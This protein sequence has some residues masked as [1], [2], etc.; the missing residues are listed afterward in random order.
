[1]TEMNIRNFC[2]ISHVDHGKST[3]AD[4]FLELTKTISYEKMKPQYLDSMS[5]ERERGITIKLQPVTM[6]YNLNLKPYVLNLIDTPGHVDFS[7]EVSRSL[8]AVEGAILLVDAGQGIQAQTL[9]NFYLARK[10]G[11][12]VI[13][14]V[15]KIDLKDIDLNSVRKELAD[16]TGLRAEEI[17]CISAKNGV[18]IEGVLRAV[19]EKIPVP[20]RN[21]KLPFRALIFDS[22]FDEFKGVVAYVRVV[23]GQIKTGDKIEFLGSEIESQVLEVGVF[24]PELKKK[25]TLSSGEIG[26]IITGLKNIEK[27]RV[28]DTI[29]AFKSETDRESGA[30][31][32]RALPGYQEPQSMV[33]AGIYPKQGA[34]QERLR[35]ALMKLKLNDASLVFEPERSLALGFGFRAGFLGLLHLDIIQERLKREYDLDLVITSPSVAYRLFKKSPLNSVISAAVRPADKKE[36]FEIIHSPSDFPDPSQI[37]EVQEPW[38]EIDIITPVFYLGAIMDLLSKVAKGMESRIKF[39]SLEYIGGDKGDLEKQQRV[40]IHYQA[41]LSL[42]L[43]D[44]YDKIK[45]VSQGFASY[46]YRFINYQKADVVKLDILV[47]GD[48]VDQLSTIVYRDWAYS[49]GRQIVEQLKT[50]LPRQLFEVKIQAAVGGKILASEKMP[51]MRKNVTAKLYGGD[52]TRKMKLLNK[53]KRGKKKLM[54]L[55]RV[56]IPAEAYWAITKR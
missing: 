6:Q 28:G 2:I 32:V 18:N 46:S 14:V 53:Q 25:E 33:F 15:N 35:L 7:Y 24:L 3:L 10:Q 47:A 4:R 36:G 12:A 48:S 42:I 13:P 11:L 8:A 30:A 26:Y 51:S 19:V 56:D 54:K 34:D 29:A 45:S 23:D 41:P 1:M 9:A 40:I 17:I 16:L 50:I 37:A 55:G 38:M 21:M 31:R 20:E 5:L 22:Y 49:V 44:F 52:V 27:C 39:V 43:V